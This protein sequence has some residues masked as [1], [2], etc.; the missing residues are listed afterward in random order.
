MAEEKLELQP[1][2]ER[3]QTQR[4]AQASDIARAPL[5]LYR[6]LRERLRGVAV[7]GVERGMCQGCR[8]T[9]P[10][11]IIQK[12]RQPGALVQCVSCERILAF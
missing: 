11:N 1:E 6:L 12:A 4:D 5:S 8:I 2:A 10:T 7:A 3:L 9:L